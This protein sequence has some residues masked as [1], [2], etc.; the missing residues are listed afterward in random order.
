M[1]G[2]HYAES[3]ALGVGE[4]HEIRVIRV[5]V[6]IDPTGTE[7]NQA[8]DLGCLLDF[9]LDNEIHVY[10]GMLLG[11]RLSS[12]ECNSGALASGWDEDGELVL[13]S[14]QLH[15]CVVEHGLPG[16]NGAF[17]VRRTHDDGPEPNHLASMAFRATAYAIQPE[18]GMPFTRRAVWHTLGGAPISTLARKWRSVMLG[19][20]T[21]VWIVV[22]AFGLFVPA[23]GGVGSGDIVT[24][25]R[26]VGAFSNLDIGGGVNVELTID[27]SSDASVSVSYDGNLLDNV[28]TEVRGDTLVIELN[29]TI[30]SGGGADRVVR[31]TAPAIDALDVSGGADL[32]GSGE[33][34]AFT[35]VASGGADVD[36][37]DLLANSVVIDASGGA[38]V[39]VYAI[40]SVEGNASGG[41]DVRV[42]GGPDRIA[43]ETSGGADLDIEG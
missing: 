38:D 26:A 8:L 34:D 35:V 23:C 32:V 40:S 29:G 39:E 3:V 16:R 41:A 4:N 9:V 5:G 1:A 6:P 28:V 7:R 36:L 24:E 37:I 20:Q 27:P 33:I 15:R 31:V 11:W 42:L 22:I 10:P 13:R 19:R 17:D 14:R 25:I 30:I 21:R 18:A 12:L 43:I 2:V